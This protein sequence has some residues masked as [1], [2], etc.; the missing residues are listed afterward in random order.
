MSETQLSNG[1]TIQYTTKAV[2][3]YR[4][5]V[6]VDKKH[7]RQGIRDLEAVAVFGVFLYFGWP[8]FQGVYTLPSMVVSFAALVVLFLLWKYPANTNKKFALSKE[9]NAP[10]VEM[11]FGQEGI[12]VNEGAAPYRIEFS[13]DCYGLEYR[14]VIALCFDKNRVLGIPTD[15][16]E[17]ETV[18]QI[19]EL[20]KKGLGD[21]FQFIPYKEPKRGNR[22][23]WLD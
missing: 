8:I 6:A 20:L 1:V 4:A 15:Q 22:V 16:L 12:Q 3:V 17:E 2:D 9:K 5:A 14:N 21:R 13:G 7:H 19:K 11:A 23:S 10:H 18:G